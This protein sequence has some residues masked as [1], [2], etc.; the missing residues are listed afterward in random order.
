MPAGF[1]EVSSMLLG[2]LLLSV[3]LLSAA[4]QQDEKN[5]RGQTPMVYFEHKAARLDIKYYSEDNLVGQVLDGYLAA[6]C[7]LLPEAAT[8]L[9]KVASDLSQK[10]YG[11]LIFDCYRPQQAVSHFMRWS[12]AP[13]DY[14]SKAAFYPNEHKQ[15]LFERGYIAERSGHSRGATVDLGLY[16]LVTGRPIDFGTRFDFMDE[17][18]ATGFDLQDKQ[19]KK[20]RQLLLKAMSKH[21]FVNYPQEWWHYTYQPEPYP[22]SYFN[23][24][25]Q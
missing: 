19:A 23:M 2:L 10:G 3:S 12:K 25:V 5:S 22:D 9:S 24:P 4:Q 1:K 15:Q 16:D 8:A 21:G 20:N 11:L 18:S 17:R 13:E 7:L 6:V 14:R